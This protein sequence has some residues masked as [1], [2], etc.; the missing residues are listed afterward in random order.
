ME[1]STT[2]PRKVLR[3]FK[4]RTAMQC[5]PQTGR[6]TIGSG[7]EEQTENFLAFFVYGYDYEIIFIFS[8]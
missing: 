1:V 8:S 3:S 2:Y 6:L 4:S 7:F 5:E